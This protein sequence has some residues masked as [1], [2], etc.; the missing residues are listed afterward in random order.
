M[1]GRPT[2]RFRLTPPDGS[3]LDYLRESFEGWL[4]LLVSLDRAR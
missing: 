3:E 4:G 2:T 1:T